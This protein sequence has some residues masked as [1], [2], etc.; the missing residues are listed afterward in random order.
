[1]IP[2][3]RES[4]VVAVAVAVIT[5]NNVGRASRDSDWDGGERTAE[6]FVRGAGHQQGRQDRRRRAGNWPSQ[7]GLSPHQ[8]GAD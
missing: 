7:H 6:D 1:M 5:E 2:R 4:W 3:A 8:Q